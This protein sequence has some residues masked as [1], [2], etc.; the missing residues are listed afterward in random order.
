MYSIMA[1]ESIHPARKSP[2]FEASFGTKAQRAGD[3]EDWV[4]H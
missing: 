2:W 4:A 3:F 1:Q